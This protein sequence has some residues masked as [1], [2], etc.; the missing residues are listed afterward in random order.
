MH[1]LKEK[2]FTNSIP[3]LPMHQNLQT[4][5][6][7]LSP[8]NRFGFSLYS[9][10]ED[11]NPNPMT[12]PYAFATHLVEVQVGRRIESV[13]VPLKLIRNSKLWILPINKSMTNGRRGLSGSWF[14]FASLH[15]DKSNSA[16]HSEW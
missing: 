10:H 3:V 2:D 8:Q 4:Q 16:A 7:T 12:C 1:S 9:Y 6:C 15:L 14:N 13:V 5:E 11:N